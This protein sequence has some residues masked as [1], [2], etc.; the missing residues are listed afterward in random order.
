MIFFWSLDATPY[1]Y[2]TF[3]YINY[4][5]IP[6]KHPRYEK[7]NGNEGEGKKD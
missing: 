4:Y 3:T 7:R 5:Y 1:L 2:L 6:A